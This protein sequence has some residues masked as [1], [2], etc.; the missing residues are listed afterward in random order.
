M[1]ERAGNEV[2]CV[3]LAGFLD[4]GKKIRLGGGLLG[5]SDDLRG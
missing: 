1:G 4:S 3:T 2:P 5:L